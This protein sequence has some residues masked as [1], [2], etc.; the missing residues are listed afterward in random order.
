MEATTQYFEKLFFY[1]QVVDFH[2]SSKILCQ[3]Y[4]RQNHWS[5]L[6]NSAHHSIL[7]NWLIHTLSEG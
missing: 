1:S 3:I 2:S 7:D 6:C 5:L 4:G